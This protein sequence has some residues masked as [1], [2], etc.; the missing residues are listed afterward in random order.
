[1][2]NKINVKEEVNIKEEARVQISNKVSKLGENI[3]TINFP[4]L[5][6]CRANAPC[7]HGCYALKG[8][9]LFQKVQNRFMK[10]LEAYKKNPTQFWEDIYEGSK[11][12]TYFR[13]FSSGD[14][15]DYKFIRGM[16]QVA[17]RNPHTKYLCFTKRYEWVNQW[18]DEKHQIP[19]NLQFVFSCWKDFVPEN[20]YHFPMTFVQFPKEPEYDCYIPENAIPCSGSC[21]SCQACWNMKKGESVVFRKH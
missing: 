16:C 21:A 13:Y 9:F 5:V 11:F 20:P 18:K 4:A 7:R 8:H 6:T 15:P 10:N 12:Y 17:R 14:I 19:K 2:S 1:M 3:P